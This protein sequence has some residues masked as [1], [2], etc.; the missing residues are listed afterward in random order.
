MKKK[1]KM[2]TEVSHFS[3]L[4]RKLPVSLAKINPSHV[5]TLKK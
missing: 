5:K 4:W 2:K 3:R 1:A